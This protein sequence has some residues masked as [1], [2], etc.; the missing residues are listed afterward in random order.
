MGLIISRGVE[1]SYFLIANRQ[2]N[3]GEYIKIRNVGFD[4]YAPDSVSNFVEASDS[5]VILREEIINE[6]G[7]LEKVI[8]Q[9]KGGN[10]KFKTGKYG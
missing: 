1:E 3:S 6:L 9:I 5:I 4:I 8:G 7:G 10:F 2:I